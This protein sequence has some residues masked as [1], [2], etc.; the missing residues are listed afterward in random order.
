M[1][2]FLAMLLALC[3][4]MG[5]IVIVSAE[6][7]EVVEHVEN[8]IVLDAVQGGGSG[9]YL[10]NSGAII[11]REMGAGTKGIAQ[12]WYFSWFANDAK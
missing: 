5:S 4:I 3:M 1:K 8:E 2:K 7:G 12:C 6:E 10:E 11:D 9:D